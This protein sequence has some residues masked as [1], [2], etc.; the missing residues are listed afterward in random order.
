MALAVIQVQ[1]AFAYQKDVVLRERNKRKMCDL[2]Y[3]IQA[4]NRE[5]YYNWKRQPNNDVNCRVTLCLIIVF[6]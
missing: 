2:S 6:Y 1:F 4:I 5:L 3:R